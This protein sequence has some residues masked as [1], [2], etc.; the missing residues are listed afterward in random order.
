MRTR[1]YVYSLYASNRNNVHFSSGLRRTLN[2]SS[3]TLTLDEWA[4]DRRHSLPPVSNKACRII[5]QGVEFSWR[6]RLLRVTSDLEAIFSPI[7]LPF[8]KAASRS[9]HVCIPPETSPAQ[10]SAPRKH[11]PS[12]AARRRPWVTVVAVLICVRRRK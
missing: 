2:R 12:A 7:F 10:F 3:F 11:A 9:T 4:I 6:G 8:L 1:M 5:L